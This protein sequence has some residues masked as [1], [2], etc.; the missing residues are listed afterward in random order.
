MKLDLHI[1]SDNSD[2][3]DSRETLRKKSKSLGLELVAITDHDVLSHGSMEDDLR[4]VSGVEISAIH[5]DGLFHILGYN[6]DCDNDELSGVVKL[7]ITAEANHSKFKDDTFVAAYS[8]RYKFDWE[9]YTR[10]PEG[11]KP[12]PGFQFRSKA[13]RYFSKRGLCKDRR[14]FFKRLA[15]ELFP[16][17]PRWGFAAY[18][19]PE[20]AIRAIKA[21]GGVAILAHPSAKRQKCPMLDALSHLADIGID[22]FEC[23]YPNADSADIEICIRWCKDN[24]LYISG[25]SD[26]HGGKH[27]RSLGLSEE[28]SSH[29]NL[30][31]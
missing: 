11:P 7:N 29:I 8:K 5:D 20:D 21:A 15:S 4:I 31:C 26:Y 22:G 25:G 10:F 19:T 23:F 1:H 13:H 14:D 12:E 2:G 24:N 27:K 30:P 18:G 17:G 16:G 6:V 3:L 28:E 9:D